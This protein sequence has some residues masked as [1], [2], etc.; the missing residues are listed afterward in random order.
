MSDTQ[1][2]PLEPADPPEGQGGGGSTTEANFNLDA[3][4][5][6]AADPPEGQGGTG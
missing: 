2:D 3:P 5:K 6:P 1:P 4:L